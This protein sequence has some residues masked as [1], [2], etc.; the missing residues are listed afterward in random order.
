MPPATEPWSDRWGNAQW[1]GYGLEQYGGLFGEAQACWGH[2]SLSLADD[3][4]YQHDVCGSQEWY[5]HSPKYPPPDEPAPLFVALNDLVPS[6]PSHKDSMDTEPRNLILPTSLLEELDCCGEGLLGLPPGLGQGAAP[7]DDELV[8]PPPGLSMPPPGLAG[9]RGPLLA[10]VADETAEA[11]GLRFSLPGLAAAGDFPGDLKDPVFLP[12]TP[13]TTMPTTPVSGC[14][15][16]S[17]TSGDEQLSEQREGIQVS[18]TVF[19]GAPCVRAVWRITGF[20]KKLTAGLGKPL[21]SPPFVVSG[22]SD[23]RLMIFPDVQGGAPGQGKQK[24]SKFGKLLSR[25][26]L[27]CALKLKVPVNNVPVLKFYLTLG[28][29]ARRGPFTCDFSERPVDGCDGFDLDWLQQVDGSGSLRVGVEIL[30]TGSVN[31]MSPADCN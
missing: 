18:P 30:E 9:P 5:Q 28:S 12:L 8:L 25:G 21:V 15:E 26:P 7:S 16:W 27:N 3:E 23:M 10:G 17:L 2:P 19:S 31:L 24:Q 4:C 6:L 11:G 29:C 13:K 22:V 20:C 14:T 1:Q